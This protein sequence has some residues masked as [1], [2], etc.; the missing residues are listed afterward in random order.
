VTLDGA[1]QGV[2]N[3]SANDQFQVPLFGAGGLVNGKHSVQ[4]TNLPINADHNYVD[5][6]FVR[7]CLTF[8]KG[9]LL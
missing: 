2:F 8:M 9:A 5:I 6:D 7:A 3:G 1:Q 4:L